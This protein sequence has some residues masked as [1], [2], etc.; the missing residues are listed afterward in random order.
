MQCMAGNTNEL[1]KEQQETIDA[2]LSGHNMCIFGRAGVGKT[3]VVQ[4]IKNI[5]ASKGVNCQ[6][7]CRSGVSCDACDGIAATVHSSYGLQTAKMPVDI[8]IQ[9]ALSRNNIVTQFRGVDVIIWDEVSMSSQQIFELVNALHD[10]LS[11]NRLA[12]GGIQVILVG[13]F[14]QLNPLKVLQIKE[15]QL[16]NPNS[17][18]LC[19]LIK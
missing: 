13:D 4:T 12:F 7:I 5:L 16:M 19:F 14:W 2:A 6:I 1:T 9:R 10:N 8:L 11:E 15:N 17:S 18:M 3:T